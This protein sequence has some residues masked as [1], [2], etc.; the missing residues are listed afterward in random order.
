[1]TCPAGL[2]GC[3]RLF[4]FG[5]ELCDFEQQKPGTRDEWLA[6]IYLAFRCLAVFAC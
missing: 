1:M 2:L 5:T 6:Y 4:A 3:D